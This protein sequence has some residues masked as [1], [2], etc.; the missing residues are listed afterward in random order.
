VR[1][2]VVDASV[3]VSALIT[4]RDTPPS[5]VLRAWA[6]ERFELV[7][8]P[9]LISEVAGVLTRPKFERYVTPDEVSDFVDMLRNDAVVHA[10]PVVVERATRDP[11]DDY[12]V[13]L[14][15]AA[16]AVLVSSDRDVLEADIRDVDVLSAS[17]FLDRLA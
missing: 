1:R 7:V 5:Q 6:R 2:A 4:Q 17:E 8:S 3:L 15:K 9:K 13:A 10:D 16:E 14:A 12:L 11:R